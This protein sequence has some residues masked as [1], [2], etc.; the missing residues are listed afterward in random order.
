MF[1]EN[2]IISLLPLFI[3]IIINILFEEFHS[4]H[5][6]VIIIGIAYWHNKRYIV[7]KK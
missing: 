7:M 4:F 2:V 6:Y 3:I 1:V 5:F